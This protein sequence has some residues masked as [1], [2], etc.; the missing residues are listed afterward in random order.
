MDDML[1]LIL[2]L[3]GLISSCT[4]PP[5]IYEPRFFFFK[6]SLGI[7]DCNVCVIT[8]LLEST[9]LYD[10]SVDTAVLDPYRDDAV[11]QKLFKRELEVRYHAKKMGI[12]GAIWGAEVDKFV[13]E[14]LYDGPE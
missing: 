13:W 2:L 12:V 8:V 10:A 3:G 9:P 7:G 6:K 4:Q 11:L 1:W 14:C 5:P